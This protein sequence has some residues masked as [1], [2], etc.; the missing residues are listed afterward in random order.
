M[1]RGAR[2]ATVHGTAELD[3]TVTKEKQQKQQ[4]IYNVVLI[5]AMQQ[6]DSVIHI[7]VYIIFIMY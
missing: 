5:S 2:W 4:L 3:T 7:Y 6:S 1:D